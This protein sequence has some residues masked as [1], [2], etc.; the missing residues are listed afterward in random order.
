[1]RWVEL[2]QHQSCHWNLHSPP[3]R[4]STS[5]SVRHN[6]ARLTRHQPFS[7]THPGGDPSGKHRSHREWVAGRP[8]RNTLYAKG[9]VG[10]PWTKR[11]VLSPPVFQA[12]TRQSVCGPFAGCVQQES[13]TAGGVGK[14]KTVYPDPSLKGRVRYSDP[15]S[16]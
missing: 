8:D 6:A 9:L 2:Y 4:A 15:A 12:R 13:E 5:P 7:H 1:M 14:T 10:P 11:S 3:H 16:S